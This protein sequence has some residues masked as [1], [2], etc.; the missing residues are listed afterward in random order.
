MGNISRSP[1]FFLRVEAMYEYNQVFYQRAHAIRLNKD[2]SNIE[3]L[4]RVN[5]HTSSCVLTALQLGEF[6]VLNLFL[7]ANVRQ[8][9]DRSSGRGQVFDF[10]Q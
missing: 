10:V 6:T 9:A 3:E 2:S 7:K 4:C 8:S 1:V 5:C